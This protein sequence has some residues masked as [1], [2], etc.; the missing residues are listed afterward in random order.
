MKFSMQSCSVW[1]GKKRKPSCV[2]STLTCL[3]PSDPFRNCNKFCD[4]LEKVLENILN[5]TRFGL[6]KVLENILNRK[7]FWKIF[8]IGKC[9][10]KYFELEKVLENILNWKRFWYEMYKL[11]CIINLEYHF[12]WDKHIVISI[13]NCIYF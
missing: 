13:L 9:F 2:C 6:E 3:V 5:W 10:G 4:E 1:F 7:M 11:I 8:W 12:I